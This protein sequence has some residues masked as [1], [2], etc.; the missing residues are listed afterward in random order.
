MPDRTD[1]PLDLPILDELGAELSRAFA[2]QATADA[3]TPA[4]SV[5]PPAPRRSRRS[6]RAPRP[7]LRWSAAGVAGIATVAAVIALTSGVGDGG[8]SPEPAT[9]ATVLRRAATV[10]EGARPALPGPSQYWYRDEVNLVMTMQITTNT[11][12]ARDATSFVM[13]R[14]R[15]WSSATQESVFLQRS[16]GTTAPG[17]D[18][19]A[20][21]V[22]PGAKG[23]RRLAPVVEG[24]PGVERAELGRMAPSLAGERLTPRAVRA[25]PTDPAAIYARLRRET[26]GAGR[27]PNGEVWVVINDALRDVPLPPKIAAGLYRTLATMPGVRLDGDTTDRL[28]RRA[29]QISFQEPGTWERQILL[30][31]PTTYARLGDREVVTAAVGPVPEGVDPTVTTVRDGVT[32]PTKDDRRPPYPVGTVTGESLVLETGVAD[33]AGG[34]VVDR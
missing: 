15:T 26:A 34:P 30:L 21:A 6:L 13:S 4:A 10:V 17:A 16:L 27:S 14:R 18:P 3:V 25:Y 5:V 7:A 8:I 23:V 29:L 11:A 24:G 20:F 12:D 9:A 2:T 32:V 31:D 1:D 19:P 22:G 28:G 33:R